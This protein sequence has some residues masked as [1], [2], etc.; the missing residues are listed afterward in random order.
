[1]VD[2]STLTPAVAKFQT[3]WK[4]HLIIM[5]GSFSFSPTST[6]SI[7]GADVTAIFPH[8]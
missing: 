4:Y 1:M 3:V 5:S 8:L 7:G 2:E 6:P